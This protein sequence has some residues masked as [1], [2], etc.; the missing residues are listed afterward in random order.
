MRRRR[1]PTDPPAA[2]VPAA[3]YD[4]SQFGRHRLRAPNGTIIDLPVP[5]VREATVWVATTWPDP[6][7]SA[8]WARQ[9]WA[10]DPATRRG[11]QLPPQL[12]AGDVLEFGADTPAGYVRWYGIMD[13]YEVDR[14]ATV[15]GPYVDPASAWSDAQ[16]LLA[17]ERFVEP[18]RTEP[19]LATGPERLHRAPT[20]RR[21]LRHPHGRGSSPI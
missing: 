12:A 17:L 6:H 15:Q 3:S 13:S 18:L 11:W 5:V 21:H 19:P 20:A 10:L 9:I 8:G 16:R 2:H 1:Q 7:A 4:W 14:W